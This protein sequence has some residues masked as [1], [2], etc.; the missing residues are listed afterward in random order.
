MRFRLSEFI[1]ACI[2]AATLPSMAP[3]ADKPEKVARSKP[4]FAVVQ[5]EGWSVCESY[6]RFLNAQPESESLPLCHLKLSPDLKE[7]NWETLD[8]Q[9]HLETIYSMEYPPGR[10]SQNPDEPPPPFE[11]WKADFGRQLQEGRTPRLRRTQLAIVEGGAVETI[12]AYE[13]DRRVC[14]AA[15]GE[16]LY[17]GWGGGERLWLWDVQE[18][19]IN[20]FHSRLA[21]TSLPRH[22]LLFQ[23]KLFV[24][25][26][27]WNR[28]SQP[29]DQFVGS[30]DVRQIS[31]IP[32]SGNPYAA[33][34]RCQIGFD[35]SPHIVERTTQ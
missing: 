22:L 4:R 15:V 1:V 10:V 29:A 16:K 30:I 23:G 19:K 7:P 32:G 34:K 24:F 9:A 2:I 25:W 28:V 18:N 31:H 6:A 27:G 17:A 35:L 21:F 5:G 8:I 26:I 14:G 11:H 20:E 3:A 13:G 33:L 12:L